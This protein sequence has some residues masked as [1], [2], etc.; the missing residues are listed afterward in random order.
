MKYE[1]EPQNRNVPNEELLSDLKIAAAKLGK[2]SITMD[3]YDARGSFSSETLRRRFGSWLAATDK[4]GLARTR[5]YHIRNEDLFSNLADVWTNL[6]RQPRREEINVQNSKFSGSTYQWRFGTWRKAL[7]AFVLWANSNEL[8]PAPDE[9]SKRTGRKTPRTINSRLRWRVLMRD[10]NK[11]RLCGAT[12]TEEIRLHVDHVKPWGKGGE[13]VLENLQ[14][15][16]NVCNLGKGD[17]EL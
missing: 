3:E 16:C 11:C 7:E 5:N 4:A 9:A 8:L 12:Q 13:A 2:N 1:L 17:V 15:L 10:G 6:G 14:I